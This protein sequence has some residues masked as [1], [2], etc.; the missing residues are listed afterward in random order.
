MI[1][2]TDLS[3]NLT[4]L[5]TKDLDY[6]ED[7]KEIITYSIETSLLAIIG[8]LL[9]VLFAMIANVLK[10]ALIAAFFGVLLRRV[11]GGAHFSTPTKCLVFG[12]VLYT[13][14]GVLAETFVEYQVLHN[15]MIWLSLAISLLIVAYLA[16]VDSESK[17]IHSKSLRKKLKASSVGFVVIA[18]IIGLVSADPL[19]NVSMCLGILYQSLTLLPLFNRGGGG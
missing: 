6:D 2:L 15:Y 11:S 10:P 5:I 1:D 16:P 14:L 19:L 9:L 17:P 3:N 18:L 13:L 8:T 12:A 7:K 4:N